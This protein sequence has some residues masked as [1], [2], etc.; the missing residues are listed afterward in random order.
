LTGGLLYA[1][2]IDRPFVVSLAMLAVTAAITGRGD[3]AAAQGVSG[4]GAEV[5]GHHFRCV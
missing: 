1:G 5:T 4:A 2:G 3:G